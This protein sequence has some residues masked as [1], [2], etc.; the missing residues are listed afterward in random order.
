MGFAELLTFSSLES[1]EY[2]SE[3]VTIFTTWLRFCDI[4]VG[5][6]IHLVTQSGSLKLVELT[7]W[8]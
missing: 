7:I 2:V 4:V 3:L 1:L 5:G 8:H 6:W